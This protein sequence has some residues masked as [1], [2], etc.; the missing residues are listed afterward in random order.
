MALSAVVLTP[1]PMSTSTNANDRA[2]NI[3]AARSAD[4]TTP[5]SDV[6][7]SARVTRSPSGVSRPQTRSAGLVRGVPPAAIPGSKMSVRSTP[8]PS[9]SA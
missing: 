4:V 1:M 6:S 9:R 3:G 5:S 8:L 2:G 7:G